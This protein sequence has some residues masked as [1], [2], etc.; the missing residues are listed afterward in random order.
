MAGMLGSPDQE[1]KTATMTIPRAPMDTQPT[2]RMGD[3][4]REMETLRTMRRA[5]AQKHRD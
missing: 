5:R 3:G 1:F 4:G 2:E